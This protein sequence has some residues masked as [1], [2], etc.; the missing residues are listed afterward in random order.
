MK[1]LF[2][3]LICLAMVVTACACGATNTGTNEKSA[4]DST[5]SGSTDTSGNTTAVYPTE[6]NL[7]TTATMVAG[8]TLTLSVSFLPTDTTV[9]NVTWESS[10][11]SILTVDENSGLM[12]AIKSGEATVTAF[13][14]GEDETLTSSCV[15]TVKSSS[16]DTSIRPA[17]QTGDF[18]VSKKGDVAAYTQEGNIYTI[19]AAGE[20]TLKGYLAGQIVVDAGD[21]DEVTIVLAGTTIAYD[22]NS[23]I[24][25]KNAD[26]VTI[27]AKSD[28]ENTI[29]DNREAKTVDVDTQGEGAISA[30]C[31]LKLAA[32]GTLYVEGNYN[33]GI[34]TTKDLKIQKLTLK[35]KAV[36]NGL[37]GKDSVTIESGTIVVIS[38]GGDGIKTENTDLSSKG[39]Q[40]G[41]ITINGGDIEIYAAGDGV[42]AAYNFE[43]NDG[44]LTVRNGSYSAYTSKNADVDSYKGIKV[45]NELNVNGGQI[46]IYSY[47]D[48][49]HADYGTTLENGGTGAG[50]INI[51]D[52]TVKISVTAS[53][54][55]YVSGADAIHADNTLNVNGGVI[56]VASAY[57]GLEANVIN[58]TGGTITVAATDDGLNAANKIGKTPS[59]TIS[60]G[61]V[62]I[63]M[64][65]GDTDGIDSNGTFTMTGGVVISRGAPNSSNSMATGLD[66]DGAAK[67][68]GGTFIQLGARET[69]LTCTG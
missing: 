16:S 56:T 45:K 30:K 47:D 51:N 15:V 3:L 24:Y 9:K 8:D 4:S 14:Q 37:K 39:N 64:A 61:Y 42:Q 21:D 65:S 55:R 69:V 62:D 43:L 50:I 67:I 68:T 25:I 33:N 59:I 6:V 23:P 49:L 29:Y 48:G 53:S 32:T 41:S 12:T 19:T 11:T 35:V 28:T 60:G 36:N 31:D 44:S 5:G 10:D 40:R 63:T 18:S 2:V 34:H 22:Q 38:T 17:D 13:A 27:K 58:I 46:V 7:S 57:E 66:C 26:S 20:Y 1:K 52:G 54:S